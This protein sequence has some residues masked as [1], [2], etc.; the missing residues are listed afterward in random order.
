MKKA[1]SYSL[2]ILLG[3]A[4]SSCNFVQDAS[5]TQPNT[6]SPWFFTNTNAALLGDIFVDV[7]HGHPN[8]PPPGSHVVIAWEMPNGVNGLAFYIFGDTTLSQIGPGKL[9]YSMFLGDSLPKNIVRLLATDTLAIAHVFLA[10]PG[11]LKNG[12]TL[13]Y[14]TLDTNLS[15]IGVLEDEVIAFRRG[16]PMINGASGPITLDDTHCG[17]NTAGNY[18]ILRGDKFPGDT[19]IR[20]VAPDFNGPGIQIDDDHN[21]IASHIVFWLQ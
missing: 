10:A 3:A 4:T 8:N 7:Q 5:F 1:F 16:N 15:I 14:S 6:P 11:V 17:R 19:K 20:D 21:D 18:I 9:V 2:F 13:L 12:D